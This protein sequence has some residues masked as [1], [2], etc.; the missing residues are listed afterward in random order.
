MDL[1]QWPSSAAEST[2]Q[3]KRGIGTGIL[4]QVAG[5]AHGLVRRSCLTTCHFQPLLH[6]HSYLMPH[7]FPTIPSPDLQFPW[8]MLLEAE[9]E[10]RDA[11]TSH[12]MSLLSSGSSSLLAH[13]FPPPSKQKLCP[14]HSFFLQL[15]AVFPPAACHNHLSIRIFRGRSKCIAFSPHPHF[16]PFDPLI[17]FLSSDLSMAPSALDKTVLG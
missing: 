17:E 3:R 1:T 13:D 4:S 6:L 15:F 10:R 5:Q 16:L 8:K 7:N 14:C 9:G 12:P 11:S 2:A